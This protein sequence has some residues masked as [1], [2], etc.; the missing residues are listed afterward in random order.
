MSDDWGVG[1]ANLK[2]MSANAFPNDDQWTSK[3]LPSLCKE[4]ADNY[5]VLFYTH[6]GRRYFE[7]PAWSSHQVTQ[8]R[9]ARRHPTSDDP[10]SVLDQEL[11]GS[12]SSCKEVPSQDQENASTE[13]GKGNRGKGTGEEEE[14]VIASDPDPPRPDVEK[15]LDLLDEQI[16]ANG[17]RAPKRNK[18]N[19][20]AMRL[21]LDRDEYSVEQV[22]WIIEWCQRDQFWQANILSASKLR[23][24][25]NTLVAQ[26]RVKSGPSQKENDNMRILSAFAG[27]E[28]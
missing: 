17:N 22:A 23:Q 20:D 15:L 6:R 16:E 24:K 9:A 2:E 1:S 13:Q 12:P 28:L 25:F 5:G 7:I 11:C 21:L 27:G 4:I 26:A 18:S 10:E 19:R 14:S 8:R 3:E